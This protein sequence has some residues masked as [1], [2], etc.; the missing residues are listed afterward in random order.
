VTGGGQ[1]EGDLIFS[2]LGDLVSLPALVPSLTDPRAQATFGFVVRCCAP[3]GNLEYNDHQAGVRIKAQSMSGL[4]ISSPGTA[5]PATP[6][7]QHARFTGTAS[8]IR[9]TGTTTEPFTVDVDDCGEPGLA[10][11]FGIQTT[12]YANG[13]STLI[14]GNIQIHKSP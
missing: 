1:I 3:T 5:C 11:T 9:S 12:T 8:V 10:D 4:F 7:S 14:G 6:G 2:P 13:P